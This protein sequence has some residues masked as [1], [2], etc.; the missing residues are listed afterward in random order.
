MTNL[1]EAIKGYLEAGRGKV[2]S[3]GPRGFLVTVGCS[4]TVV[5]GEPHDITPAAAAENDGGPSAS[6]FMW[7]HFTS[8]GSLPTHREILQK[9]DKEMVR[10]KGLGLV[11]TWI[12]VKYNNL[13]CNS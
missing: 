9:K 3:V 5:G 10:R 4:K 11:H 12:I 2:W 7:N 13:L 6:I 8:K 1:D